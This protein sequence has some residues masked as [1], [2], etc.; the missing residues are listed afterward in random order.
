MT[1]LSGFPTGVENMG[2]SSKCDEGAW[3]NAGKAA[4]GAYSDVEKYLWRGSFVAKVAGSK[5]ATLQTC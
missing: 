2:G 4:G 3:V 1:H 5:P